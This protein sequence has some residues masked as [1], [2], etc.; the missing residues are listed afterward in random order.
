MRAVMR[1]N[2]VLEAVEELTLDEQT[3]L[4]E[5]VRR[6]VAEQGRQRLMAELRESRAE[7]ARGEAKITSIDELM[8]EIES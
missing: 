7:F 6:R 3:E 5:V 1:F 8:K 4:V 2:D